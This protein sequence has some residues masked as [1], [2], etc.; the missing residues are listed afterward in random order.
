[1]IVCSLALRE[2]SYSPLASPLLFLFLFLRERPEDSVR[3]PRFP[4]FNSIPHPLSPFQLIVHQ[5]ET[6]DE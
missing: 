3:I 5:Q 1:M 2:Q 6:R 4:L